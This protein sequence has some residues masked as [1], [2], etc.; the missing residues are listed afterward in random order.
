MAK[1]HDAVL[2]QLI[3]AW[4][5]QWT[6]LLCEQAGLSPHLRAEPLDADLSIASNQADKLFRLEGGHAGLLHL[7]LESSWAGGQALEDLLLYNV[8]AHHRYGG[9]VYSVLMLLRRQAWSPE[10]TGIHRRNRADGR[11]IH[12]FHYTPVRVWDLSCERLLQGPLG[13]LPL[14]LLTDEAQAD[15]RQTIARIDQRLQQES[16]APALGDNLWITCSLL[17]GMRIEREQALRLFQGARTMRDS[18]VYQG[19]LEEGRG[20]GELAA[21]RRT[22]RRQG[23]LRFG[24]PRPE[25]EMVLLA[26]A[27]IARLER[28]T[29]RVVTDATDWTDLLSTP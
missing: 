1:R 12:E 4:S 29:D 20:E 22:V 2:K 27:D 6:S 5:P 21:L 26:I 14:A 24:S 13:T 28:M 15:V 3:D 18:S 8:L 17:L 7:E 9:P 23:T 25:E 11:P 10:I 19:I 16:L